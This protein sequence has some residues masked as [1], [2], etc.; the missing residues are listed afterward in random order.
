MTLK[1]RVRGC[2]QYGAAISLNYRGGSSYKTIGGGFA[3]LS[4]QL[5][6]F[7]FFCMQLTAVVTY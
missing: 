5:L 3:S 6:I 7:A 4:I 2:D 1:D